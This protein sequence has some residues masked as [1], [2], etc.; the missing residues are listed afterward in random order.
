VAPGP[1][2]CD[3]SH[4]PTVLIVDDH[5][6]FRAS[7][8]KLLELDGFEVVGEAEDGASGAALAREL[9]PEVVLLDVAL[10]DTSGFEVADQL[11]ESSSTIVLVS[12]RDPA[13]FGPK[14]AASGAAGFIPKERL[15]TDAI[16]ALLDEAA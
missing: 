1:S 14:V 4:V 11:R 5:R 10:P 15:T 13:D 9:E 12:S 2:S 6:A 16:R 8:R 7:A 3:D